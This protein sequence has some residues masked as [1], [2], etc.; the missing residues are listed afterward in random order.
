VG[1][2]CLLSTGG[3]FTGSTFI[4][5]VSKR[6]IPYKQAKQVLENQSKNIYYDTLVK[7]KGID[8][9]KTYQTPISF[10]H[11][12]T[13]DD[14]KNGTYIRYFCKP[15]NQNFGI[16][17]ISI[18]VYNSFINQE[19]K[20][21]DEYYEVIAIDWKITGPLQDDTSNSQQIIHGVIDTNFRNVKRNNMQFKGLSTYLDN[22]KEFY[23][24]TE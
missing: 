16:I 3:V 11:P 6:L 8:K 13:E 21:N 9:I 15:R 20:Y 2:Y 1:Y 18:D 19:K 17:E 7:D 14:Y 24:F 12:P 10:Y 5:N 22:F 23:R 4:N